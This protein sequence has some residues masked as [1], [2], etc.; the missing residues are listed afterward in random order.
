M[1]QSTRRYLLAAVSAF[2]AALVPARAAEPIAEDQFRTL[3][4]VIKPAATEDKWAQI[5]WLIDLWEARR[6]AASEGKPILLWEM[7]GH[8]LACV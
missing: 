8:P 3:Q 4:A 5:P 1:T 2:L 7:D 6:R